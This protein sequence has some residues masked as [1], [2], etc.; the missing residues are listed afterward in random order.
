MKPQDRENTLF[1]L[2]KFIQDNFKKIVKLETTDFKNNAD[3]DVNTAIDICNFYAGVSRTI[4]A[5]PQDEYYNT[6]TSSMRYEPKGHC[7][8]VVPWNY[9]LVIAMWKIAPAIAA[10]CTIDVKLN[11]KNKGSV[12]FIFSNWKNK[13]QVNVVDTVDFS[14][15]DFIDIT[16]SKTTADFFKQHHNDVI[17]DIGGASVAIV[18][19]GNISFIANSLDWSIKY[20]GGADCTSPKHIFCKRNLFAQLIE[21]LNCVKEQQLTNIDHFGPEATMSQYDNLQELI[22]QINQLPNRLGLHLYT[23]ELKTQRFVSQHARWGN[24]FVN[25]PMTTPIEMPHSGVGASGNTFNQGANKIY[26][27]LVPKHVIVGDQYD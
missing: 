10:G 22:K 26:Q 20:N 8:G 1:S 4:T 12:P 19:D 3:F 5:P 24:I 11:P 7:L 13:V 21:N 16:G 18:N 15:Y 27:Y 23:T 9:P 17:A 14:I 2:S 6:C 25:K